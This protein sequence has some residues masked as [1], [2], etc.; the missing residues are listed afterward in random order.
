[1]ARTTLAIDADLLAQAMQ[2]T[3]ARSKTEVVEQALRVLIQTQASQR[4][5]ES[6]G[7]YDIDLTREELD[8]L[9]AAE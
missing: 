7:T 6:L 4:L 3:D 5:L 1:M 9:R 2:A 8:R